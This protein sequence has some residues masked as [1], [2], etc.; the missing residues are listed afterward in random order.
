MKP[1]YLIRGLPGHPLHPPITDAAIGAYTVATAAASL[2]V[3]GILSRS[4]AAAW[5]VAL[6]IGIVF[7]LLAATSGLA[8]WLQL[9][10][11]TPIFRTATSHMLV[12]LTGTALFVVA[13]ILGHAGYTKSN[14]DALPY[15]FT[16]AGFA[17]L[18]VGGWLGGAIVF[19]H[20]MRVLELVE[21]P[22]GRA[23]APVPHPEKERA[24]GS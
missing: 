24:E 19:V 18:A 15:A 11:G 21:E 4:G 1:S 22:A 12:M 16:V 2:Q 3:A 10:R 6:V 8:D 14:V 7:G 23:V 5:W 17:V 9:E 13:A 20:G